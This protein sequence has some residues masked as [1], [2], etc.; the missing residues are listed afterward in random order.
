MIN[1]QDLNRL[2]QA[3]EYQ[4]YPLAEY[5]F[6]RRWFDVATP[7]RVACVGGHTNLDL[8][9]ASQGHRIDAVNHDPDEHYLGL[10]RQ[11]LKPK[12]E[13]FQRITDY[14]GS[15]QWIQQSISDLTQVGEQDMIWLSAH[16]DGVYDIRKWPAT[17]VFNHY[18]AIARSETM[19]HI[20]TQLPLRAL[21]RRLAV[22]SEHD[23]DLEHPT[24]MLTPTRFWGRDTWE[25]QS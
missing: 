8:F 2:F 14:Q 11:T 21:G 10:P 13:E 24:Y 23:P 4:D 25:I 5:Q 15:Y 3:G 16:Q 7:E 20:Q 1:I 19:V 12:H 17:I 9:Y 6:M 22:F 18:G